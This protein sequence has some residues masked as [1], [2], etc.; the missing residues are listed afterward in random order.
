MAGKKK[1]KILREIRRRIADEND[2]PFV[3]EECR[4]KGDCTGTCPKC[5]SELRYLERQLEKRRALGKTVT[6]SALAVGVAASFAGC[7]AQVSGYLA[8]NDA[9]TVEEIVLEGE[10][11]DPDFSEA[12]TQAD[13][14][15][16]TTEAVDFDL[17]ENVNEDVYGPPMPDEEPD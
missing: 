4:Y 11:A 2:I 14:E 3:T 8:E 13:G 9:T 1:C 10:V 7:R 17:S 5:E 12:D 15:T 6:V 16:E